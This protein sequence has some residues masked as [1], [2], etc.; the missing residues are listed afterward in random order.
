MANYKPGSGGLTAAD[1][2]SRTSTAE[3]ITTTITPGTG[4]QQV[5]DVY[6]ESLV[7]NISTI[8]W[9][10]NA[11]TNYFNP[12]AELR[13]LKSM[14][15]TSFAGVQ[16]CVPTVRINVGCRWRYTNPSTVGTYIVARMGNK[17]T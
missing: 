10:A 4:Q 17:Y 11:G 12:N 5:F 16:S 13:T 3:D 9:S 14:G 7:A 15:M 6:G 1:I 2:A 8:E